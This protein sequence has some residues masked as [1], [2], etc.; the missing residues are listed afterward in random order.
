MP[1][2]NW[3]AS[4]LALL[5]GLLFALMTV[6]CVAAIAGRLRRRLRAEAAFYVVLAAII[7]FDL[8]VGECIVTTGEKRLR[9]L[10]EPGSAYTNSFLGH[11]APWLPARPYSVVSV[12]LVA[13]AVLAAPAWRVA[14]QWRRQ[15]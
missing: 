7:F 15:T 11:Y 4:A 5:H 3:F 10:A 12:V 2:L 13:F 8:V 1:A 14:D 9:D 6:G